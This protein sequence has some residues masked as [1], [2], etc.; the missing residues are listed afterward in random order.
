LTYFVQI[1]VENVD[2]SSRTFFSGA[3]TYGK[4]GPQIQGQAEGSLP[5]CQG[6]DAKMHQ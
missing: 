4:N 5:S 6:F 3:N 1:E 2:K